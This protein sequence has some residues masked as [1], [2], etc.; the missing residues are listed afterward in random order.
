MLGLDG[1][2]PDVVALLVGEGKLPNFERLAREGASGRLTSAPPL[3]SPI[4]WTTVATGREPLDHGV[5]GFVT[6]DADG[7]RR[8]VSSRQRRVRAL[9]NMLSESDRTVAVVGWW[10]TWPAEEVRGTEIPVAWFA[11][12]LRIVD[13]ANPHAPREIACFV[14]PVP[15]GFE[16]VSSNDVCYDAQGL[17]YLIDRN[18][19]LHVL[20]RTP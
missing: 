17:L 15:P 18:R 1:V 16:R 10:A 8:P 9:W 2:D 4:L 6:L 12:G 5:S 20:E 13:I 3:L 14:P 19:G 11:H 7:E